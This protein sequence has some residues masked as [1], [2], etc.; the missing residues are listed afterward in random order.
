[1]AFCEN[2]GDISSQTAKFNLIERPLDYQSKHRFWIFPSVESFGPEYFSSVKVHI[3]NFFISQ[4]TYFNFLLSV[5]AQILNFFSSV[6]AHILN[7]FIDQKLHFSSVISS[8]PDFC[9]SGKAHILN[10]IIIQKLRS[11]IF[12]SNKSSDPDVFHQTK[13]PRSLIYSV[14]RRF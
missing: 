1:M 2:F 12:S 13:H 8:Y 11:W 5:K 7:F 6:K 3:L 14:K 4:C 9:L 10:L